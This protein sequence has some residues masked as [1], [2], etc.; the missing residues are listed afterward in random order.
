MVE[1]SSMF[2][3]IAFVP[4]LIGVFH[5]PFMR[6]FGEGNSPIGLSNQKTAVGR[7]IQ[8]LSMLRYLLKNNLK[9]FQSLSIFV[10][11]HSR[12]G[13]TEGEVRRHSDSLCNFFQ[14]LPT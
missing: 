8:S 9:Q 7:T 14:V 5:S 3:I 10:A 1:T 6:L 11:L 13:E 4:V 12:V 2:L